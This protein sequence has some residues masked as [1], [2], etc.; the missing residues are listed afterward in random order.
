MGSDFFLVN[1]TDEFQIFLLKF[2]Y[3]NLHIKLELQV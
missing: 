1:H 3:K 2:V